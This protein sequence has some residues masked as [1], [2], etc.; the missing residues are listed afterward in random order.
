MSRKTKRIKKNLEK[1]NRED[2]YTIDEAVKIIKDLEVLNFDETVELHVKLGV[3]PRHA[4]Q[5]VRGTI[6]LPHGIGKKIRV[7]VFAKGEA[8]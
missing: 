6:I 7:I 8:E 4:D 5:I 2:S 3:D 1:F